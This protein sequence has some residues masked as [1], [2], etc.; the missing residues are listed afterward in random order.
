MEAAVARRLGVLGDMPKFSPQ[1]VGLAP[2]GVA[3]AR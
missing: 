1:N 3:P 2:S